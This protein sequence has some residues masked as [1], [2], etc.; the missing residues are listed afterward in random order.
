MKKLLLFIGLVFL[1]L[2]I[3]QAWFVPSAFIGPPTQSSVPGQIPE[4]ATA[5]QVAKLLADKGIIVSPLGYRLYALLDDRAKHAVVGEYA[6]TPGASY[7]ALARQFALGPTRDE[8]TIRIIEGSSLRDIGLELNKWQVP[9]RSFLDLVGDAKSSKSFSAAL[10]SQ[11]AF[12]KDLPA[13][14]TLEGYLYPDTY[15]VW[16]DQLPL[17]FVL[18]QL[19][20]FGKKTEGFDAQAKAQSRTWPDVVILASML[21]K[22]GRTADEKKMIAG[23]FLNRLKLG[24]RLQS[25]AT[26]NYVTN[27]GRARPTLEDLETESPYNTY[28]HEGLPL[29]PICNPGQDSLEAA[30]HPTP[31]GYYYYLHDDDGKI[32]YAKT[33]E[34]HKANRA[35]AYRE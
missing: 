20:E 24:M 5:D 18:K 27:A 17:G 2:A 25:D 33:A 16:K 31:N 12:L 29:G 28:R 14:A 9:E 26:V 10:R 1:A 19:N 32:Y 34:E 22:E 15:R 13:D 11:F 6:V 3:F 8:I 7:R 23:I 21:E 30:L 35:K 4:N